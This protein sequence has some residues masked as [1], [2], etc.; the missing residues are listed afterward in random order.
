M[1]GLH[2]GR[3]LTAGLL[4]LRALD[5][6]LRAQELLRAERFR[7]VEGNAT[8]VVGRPGPLQARMAP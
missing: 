5:E 2:V 1:E 7:P 8:H 3:V 4:T 6:L